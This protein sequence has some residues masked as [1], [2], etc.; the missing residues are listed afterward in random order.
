MRSS[1]FSTG[2]KS[3]SKRGE[4]SR[5]SQSTCAWK[6]R[7]SAGKSRSQSLS[8]ALSASRKLLGSR[9]RSSW[10]F[11][12]IT[13]NRKLG[14]YAAGGPAAFHAEPRRQR[15]RQVDV[16]YLSFHHARLSH[17]LA[18]HHHPD[19]PVG[20]GVGAVIEEAVGR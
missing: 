4:G 15:G 8:S 11:A 18:Q 17:G 7:R 19:Q 5:S 12:S 20:L 10:V 14:N 1:S 2:A 16:A 6:E 9:F 3:C 13:L